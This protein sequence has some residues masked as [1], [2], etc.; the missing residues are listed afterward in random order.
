MSAGTETVHR[1]RAARASVRSAGERL[2][3][4]SLESVNACRLELEAAIQLVSE[5]PKCVE[6]RDSILAMEVR[7]LQR[8]V[9]QVRRLLRQAAELYLGWA[10]MLAAAAGGYSPHGEIVALRPDAGVSVEA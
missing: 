4:P 10:S 6:V 3:Q 9:D 1:L 2:I 8:E 5:A 7:A